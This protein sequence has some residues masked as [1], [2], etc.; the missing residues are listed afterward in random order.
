MGTA[1]GAVQEQLL[2][3]RNMIQTEFNGFGFGVKNT[4]SGIEGAFGF[5]FVLGANFTLDIQT[6]I[7]TPLARNTPYTL[8]Y[9]D[10]VNGLQT[11]SVLHEPSAP[12]Q[13]RFPENVAITLELSGS[14]VYQDF[15]QTIT[16]APNASPVL[17]PRIGFK[18]AYARITKKRLL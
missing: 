5:G 15:T 18:E 2:Q 1:A 3:P 9:V 7:R 8:T 6:V 11:V 13:A 10:P 16:I 14:L 4:L 17:R 12:F